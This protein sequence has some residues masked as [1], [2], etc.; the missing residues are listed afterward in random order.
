MDATGRKRNLPGSTSPNAS[1]I[2]QR[3]RIVPTIPDETTN[4]PICDDTVVK[5]QAG[6]DE[7]RT[8]TFVDKENSSPNVSRREFRL[9]V[10]FKFQ[11]F[12]KGSLHTQRPGLSQSSSAVENKERMGD[13]A[14]RDGIRPGALATIL[15]KRMASRQ[16][17][18][19]TGVGGKNSVIH[20]DTTKLTPSERRFL[21]TDFAS[22]PLQTGFPIKNLN[23]G[24][25]SGSPNSVEPRTPFRNVQSSAGLQGL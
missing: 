10:G 3:R 8:Q 20:K 15:Q 25:P 17:M 24:T 13:H 1:R 19:S 14:S 11:A 22:T 5:A 21:H 9:N 6:R 16:N 18:D 12:V 7:C 2:S 4:P 23:P